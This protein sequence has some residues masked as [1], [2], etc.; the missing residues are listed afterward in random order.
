MY[1]KKRLMT[2]ILTSGATHHFFHSKSSF[3]TYERIDTESV[4]AASSLSKLVGKG[5][6]KLPID[7]GIIIEAYH[8]PDF[9]ANIISVRRLL[10]SYAIHFNKD[11]TENAYC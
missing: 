7:G 8:A 5:T 11:A 1:P 4:K 3:I 10:G 6:V 2:D 9:S